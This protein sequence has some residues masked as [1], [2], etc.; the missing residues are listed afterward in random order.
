M[1]SD[2]RKQSKASNDPS[3]TGAELTRSGGV[4]HHGPLPGGPQKRPIPSAARDD[5][6]QGGEQE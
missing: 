5:L 1:T 4:E 6:P 2:E 3:M